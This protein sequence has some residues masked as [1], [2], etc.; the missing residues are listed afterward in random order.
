MLFVCLFGR[1]KGA[2]GTTSAYGVG[3]E[4]W[5]EPDPGGD[6]LT[7]RR[8]LGGLVAAAL[9]IVVCVCD[10]CLSEVCDVSKLCEV[11][12]GRCFVGLGLG[13]CETLVGSEV[14]AEGFE[15]DIDYLLSWK[16][17]KNFM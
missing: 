14:V 6:W 16:S 2:Q 3:Y 17:G 1:P 4:G 12:E 5:R 13:C 11:L 7:K 9:S 10:C 15:S 8:T